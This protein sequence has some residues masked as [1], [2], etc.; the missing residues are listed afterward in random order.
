MGHVRTIFLLALALTCAGGGRLLAG[1]GGSIYSAFGLG[2]LRYA[3]GTRAAGMGYAGI[4][5]PGTSYLNALAPGTWGTID[6]VRFEASVSMEGFSSTDG[7]RSRYLARADFAG[8][9]FS[10]PIS[11]PDRIVFVGGI[12]PYSAFNYDVYIPDNYTGESDTLDYLVHH[13]GTGGISRAL[14]GISYAP[15]PTLDLG[16]SFNVLFGSLND[17]QSQIPAAAGYYGGVAY[18]STRGHGFTI[19]LGGLYSGL[20]EITPALKDF[21]VGFTLTTR[22]RLKSSLERNY[23]YTLAAVSTERDTVA[24]QTSHIAIPFSWGIGLAYK[25]SERTTLALDYAAQPW[26][27]AEI[28]GAS[29]PSLRN[30]QRVGVGVEFAQS[31]ELYASFLARLAYRLGAYYNATYV[32]TSGTPINEYGVTAGLS[33]PFSG[34]SRLNVHGEYARRGTTDNGLVADEIFRLSISLNIST[35]WFQTY[36]EE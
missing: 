24:A 4:G 3:V 6:R 35:T 2:D 11:R 34:D 20:G 13:V 25:P 12:I 27:Q 5:V 31:K 15:I 33:L 26:A 17:E 21:T 32:Q 28:N 1:S 14:G 16:F 7:S 22:G 23:K 19:S 18:S 10:L 9:L 36:G 30:S 8:F 29:P